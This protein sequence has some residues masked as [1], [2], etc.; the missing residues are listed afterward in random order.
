[1]STA[2]S[3]SE[4][5]LAHKVKVNDG[6]Q[7]LTSSP[8]PS[9]SPTKSDV[10]KNGAYT[11]SSVS[12]GASATTAPAPPSMSKVHVRFSILLMIFAFLG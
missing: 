12:E 1:M 4:A 11:I 7:Q 3:A 10:T 9:S 2:S 5:P 8:M 6:H